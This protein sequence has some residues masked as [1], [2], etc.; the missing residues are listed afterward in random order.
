VVRDEVEE[1]AN[2]AT[3]GLG[4]EAVDIREGPEIR[5]DPGV[6]AHVVAPVDVRRRV[7]RVE[8]DSVYSEPLEV[9][10]P[11]DETGEIPDP[12]AVPVGERAGVDLIEDAL[13]PPSL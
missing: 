11:L 8:P 12:V 3:S 13:A 2:P 6:V 1:H 5:V 7:Y 4:D 9:V 10:E